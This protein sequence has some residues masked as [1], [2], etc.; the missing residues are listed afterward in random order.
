M[1]LFIV[2]GEGGVFLTKAETKIP[3]SSIVRQH[4]F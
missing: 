2:Q 1:G 3:I 4:S